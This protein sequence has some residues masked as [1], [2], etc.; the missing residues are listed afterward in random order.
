MRPGCR[1]GRAD[2]ANHLSLIHARAGADAGAKS[3]QMK[4]EGLVAVA[5]PQVDLLAAATCPAG[6]HHRA[7]RNRDDRG[8]GRGAVVDAEM[9]PEGAEHRMQP[10]ARKAGGDAWLELERRTEHEA[11]ERPA[12]AVVVGGACAVGIGPPERLVL[13]A[14]GA[15]PAPRGLGRTPRTAPPVTTSRA[16]PRSGRRGASHCRNR[17]DR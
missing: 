7:R 1:A 9:G 10:A 2:P 16:A 5:V 15:E 4:V 14:V 11:L 12:A 8:A 3:G 17:S 6:G 13:P